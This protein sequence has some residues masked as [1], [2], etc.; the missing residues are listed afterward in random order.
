MI[1]Q[2]EE[3]SPSLPKPI[4]DK[5]TAAVVNDISSAQTHLP[6]PEQAITMLGNCIADRLAT[7]SAPDYSL[8][9]YIPLT[10]A[11]KLLD[12]SQDRLRHLYYGSKIAATKQGKGLYF[13]PEWISEYV[14]SGEHRKKLL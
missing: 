1:T 3:T 13:K 2:I 10:E 11:A 12:L 9:G 7:K 5:T 6:S 4:Q 8:T 14:R